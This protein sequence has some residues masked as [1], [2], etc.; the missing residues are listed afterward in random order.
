MLVTAFAASIGGLATPV[1][2]PPNLIGIA[3]LRQQA[4]IDITFDR[5]MLVGLPMVILVLA[6]LFAIFHFLA[7][8][9]M[10]VVE[11]S[12]DLVRDELRKL[13]AITR[14]QRNVMADVTVIHEIVPR[15]LPYTVIGAVN[16]LKAA[17]VSADQNALLE[18]TEKFQ[19]KLSFFEAPT[20]PTEIHATQVALEEFINGVKARNAVPVSSAFRIQRFVVPEFTNKISKF[21]SGSLKDRLGRFILTLRDMLEVAPRAYTYLNDLMTVEVNNVL[22]H[23][24]GLEEYT[25]SNFAEDYFELCTTVEEEHSESVFQ[26]LTAA[27]SFSLGSIEL[28]Y[29]GDVLEVRHS[30]RIMGLPISL[31]SFDLSGASGELYRATASNVPEL[32]GLIK[33]MD[34]DEAWAGKGKTYLFG[35]DGVLFEVIASVWDEGFFTLVRV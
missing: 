16:D 27:V 6:G 19:G 15:G 26:R 32:F 14:G 35:A 21:N 28:G 30:Y 24:L 29:E 10:T 9:G 1:G 12:A 23:A 4:D 17:A 5:W 7:V 31:S 3:L 20:E 11:G 25:I 34:K 2:T 13:G 22:N 18:E 33:A 8:R